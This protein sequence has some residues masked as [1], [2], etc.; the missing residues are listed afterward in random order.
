MSAALSDGD[1]EALCDQVNRVAF[2]GIQT[3]TLLNIKAAIAEEGFTVSDRTWIKAVKLLK[4]R[5]VL[6]GR[7]AVSP[8]DFMVLADALWD[9]HEDRPKLVE[10]I[11]RTADP[12]GS[13]A[14]AIADAIKTALRDLPDF[15]MLR[16][17]T[18]T[19]FEFMS[20]IA[21]VDKKVKALAQKVAEMEVEVDDNSAV[22]SIRT[23]VD[24]AADTVKSFVKQA[25]NYEG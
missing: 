24:I 16:N 6:N 14:Q 11:A 10:I 13:R 15:S 5:A 9:T 25:A 1:Y 4:A 23:A 17:D 22:A 19:K 12:Y 21:P 18:L 2:N 8:S 7:T 20:K 3:D